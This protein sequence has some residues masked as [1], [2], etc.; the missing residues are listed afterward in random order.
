MSKKATMSG[1]IRGKLSS[2]S[3]TLGGKLGLKIQF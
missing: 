1:E 3:S 2:D